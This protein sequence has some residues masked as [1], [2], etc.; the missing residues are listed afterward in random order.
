LL[1]K[2]LISSSVSL[3]ALSTSHPAPLQVPCI[4]VEVWDPS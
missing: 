2:N 3:I 4:G 1:P